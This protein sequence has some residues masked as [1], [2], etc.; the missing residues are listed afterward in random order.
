MEFPLDPQHVQDE[1]EWIVACQKLTR[2]SSVPWVLL[3]GG[4]H[5][6]TYLRQVIAATRG[7][8][9]GV[10]VGRAVWKEAADLPST[11]RAG[12][13]SGVTRRRMA[14]VTGI[15]QALAK[16]WWAK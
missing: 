4:V 8:A 9:S 14:Q 16:P 10:A 5:F 3:S 2:V 1:A 11:E 13:L 7:G 15:C 12:F 6:E